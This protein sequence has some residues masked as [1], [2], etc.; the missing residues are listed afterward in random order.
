MNTYTKGTGPVT[1]KFAKGGPVVQSERSRF[2][3]TPDPFRTDIE[4]SDYE[5]KSAGGELSKTE[6][7][8]KSEKPV[9]PQA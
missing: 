3:K 2:M 9:K 1:A 7:D 5:K 6:G 4:R 8:T